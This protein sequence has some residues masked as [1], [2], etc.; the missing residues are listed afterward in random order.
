[1]RESRRLRTKEEHAQDKVSAKQGMK[2][3]REYGSLRN[4]HER[5]FKNKKEILDWKEYC[6]KGESFAEVLHTRKPD[7]I[8]RINQE[9]REEKERDRK[10]REE[11]RERREEEEKRR[12]DG[13][14]EYNGESGEYYWTGEKEPEQTVDTCVNEPLTENEKKL[15][16]ETEA[17]HFK[18]WVEERTRQRNEKRRQKYKEFKEKLSIPLDPLPERELCPYE[19]MRENNIQERKE[20]MRKCGFFEDLDKTKNDIGLN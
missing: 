14:W 19:Q 13:I 7:L 6:E 15:S 5:S 8:E 10:K 12:K 16:E 11:E 9:I 2:D 17:L 1:M 3:F 4:Y 18:W 20:A